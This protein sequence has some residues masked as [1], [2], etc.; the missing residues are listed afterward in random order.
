MRTVANAAAIFAVLIITVIF[1]LFALLWH[2]DWTWI[3]VPLLT[4]ALYVTAWQKNAP[5]PLGVAIATAVVIGLMLAIPIGFPS[6]VFAGI[7]F[8]AATA[9]PLVGSHLIRV[10]T[11]RWRPKAEASLG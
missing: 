11:R 2:A 10:L 4:T 6:T 1:L 7:F 8:I 9:I 3:V 5:I